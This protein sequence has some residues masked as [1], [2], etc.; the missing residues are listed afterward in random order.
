MVR[1]LGV[2][3]L[4]MAFFISIFPFKNVISTNSTFRDGNVLGD[5][6]FALLLGAKR[7]AEDKRSLWGMSRVFQ[8]ETHF[9]LT[10]RA[11]WTLWF[12]HEHGTEAPASA[13]GHSVQ[14]LHLNSRC[15]FFLWVSFA[16]TLQTVEPLLQGIWR[17]RESAHSIKAHIFLHLCWRAWNCFRE[18]IFF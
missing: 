2:W 9:N 11:L 5:A 12:I 7:R 16:V 10:S 3:L 13:W 14:A 18:E 4:L 15:D 8:P 1:S 6:F 17:F